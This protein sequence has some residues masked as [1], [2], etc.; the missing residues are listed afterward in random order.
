[1]KQITQNYKTGELKIENVPAPVIKKSGVLVRTHHSV[2]SGGTERATIE[3]SKKGYIGKAKSR[4]D[5]VKQVIKLVKKQGLKKSYEVVMNRLNTPVALGYSSS[6]TV[7]EVGENASEFQIGDRVSCAGVGYANHAELVFVPKNLCVKIP[8][9]VT[10]DEG[11]YATIGAIAIQ[12]LRQADVRLGEKIGVL[13]LGLIGLLT[14][15]LLKAAGCTVIGMDISDFAVK[16]A[17][18]CGA[19]YAINSAN[20]DVHSFVQSLT[21]N[22]GLDAVILTAATPSNEPVELAGELTRKKGKVVVV[23]D[24]GMNI[25]RNIYYSKEIDFKISCSYGPGR[26]DPNY[27]EYGIDY[28]F[29]YV[30]WTEKRNMEAFLRLTKEGAVNIEKISTHKYKIVD[31]EKAYDLITGKTK[32]NYIGVLLEYDLSKEIEFDVKVHDIAREK[33]SH[34]RIAMIGAG[35]FAQSEIL[36]VLKRDDSISL[37]AVLAA[38]GHLSQNVAKKFGIGK[39]ISTPDL[40]FSDEKINTIV[41]ATRHDQ[42]AHFVIEGLRN[43]KNIYVEKPLALSVNELLEILHVHRDFKK[44]VLVGFNRRFA[45]HIKRC[46]DFFSGKVAPMVINYR[47]NAGYISPDHWTQNADEGGGRIIGEVC[48]FIDLC[49]YLCKSQYKTVFAQNTGDNRLRDNVSV[50]VKFENGS[51]ANINYL[52]N[53]DTSYPKERIEVFC[54]NSIAIIDDFKRLELVSGGKQKIFK[55]TQDKGHHRQIELWINSIKEGIPVPVPFDES[56]NS[57]IATFM[58]HESLDRGEN[59]HFEAFRRKILK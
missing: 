50:I 8:E 24:V 9:G 52:S 1:M 53:G 5:Q 57:T 48:H 30:R 35:N 55:S 15:Q 26:Y 20:E 47:I 46:E 23:G 4:P 34:I 22:N 44:D 6:G 21:Q 36:P 56:V 38:E 28:P 2:I 18:N 3:I 12:G 41:I 31:A 14:V 16:N 17:K 58:I 33:S 39:C 40:I 19:D 27:E 11:A 7:I 37:E 29:G 32:E 43:N 51:L 45:P 59:I 25:P 10:F 49:Q 54:E 42:H 13:G